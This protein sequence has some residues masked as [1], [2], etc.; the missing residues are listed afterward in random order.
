MLLHCPD[1]ATPH[2]SRRPGALS[3]T[4]RRSRGAA[5]DAA[6][7]FAAASVLAAQSSRY[8]ATDRYCS[9][10][11]ASLAFFAAARYSRPLARRRSAL[12]LDPTPLSGGQSLGRNC[13]RSHYLSPWSKGPRRQPK[14][15]RRAVA[16]LLFALPL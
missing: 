15:P 1:G 9:R 6:S 10:V 12:N 13:I 7:P 3:Q 11:R 5:G 14:L 8:L 2:A 16:D 4:A